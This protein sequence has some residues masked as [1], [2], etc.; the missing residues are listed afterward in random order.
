MNFL[1]S[2]LLQQVIADQQTLID[3]TDR[4]INRLIDAGI[5]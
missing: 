4:G 5:F 2:S 1:N 3:K